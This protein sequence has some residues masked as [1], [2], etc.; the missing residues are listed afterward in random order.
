MNKST[1]NRFKVIEFINSKKKQAEKPVRNKEIMVYL[2]DT[3][4]F[5]VMIHKYITFC[6]KKYYC[7]TCISG[8]I[9]TTG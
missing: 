6:Y 1:Q 8:Y 4:I 2:I 9:V 5:F 3:S 7:T